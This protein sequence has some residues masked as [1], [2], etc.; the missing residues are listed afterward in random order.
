MNKYLPEEVSFIR[1][2]DNAQLS[3]L[4]DWVLV[5]ITFYFIVPAMAIRF[6]LRKISVIMA[7]NG[8]GHSGITG[9]IY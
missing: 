7:Y 8:K 9:Y 6:F 1:F 2:S 5:L 4:A 3:D